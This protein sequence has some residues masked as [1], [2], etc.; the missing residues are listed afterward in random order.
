MCKNCQSKRQSTR[1]LQLKNLGAIRSND[2][3]DLS[4]VKKSLPWGDSLGHEGSFATHT[5]KNNPFKVA[6]FWLNFFIRWKLAWVVLGSKL[7]Q[8][9]NAYILEVGS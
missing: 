6:T 4:I 7:V 1:L 2:K 3:I 9:I 8:I 5:P